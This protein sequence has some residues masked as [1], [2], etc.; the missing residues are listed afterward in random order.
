[1][2]HRT[3]QL[4]APSSLPLAFNSRL[5]ANGYQLTAEATGRSA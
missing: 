2:I 1:M 3:H 5:T 4:L